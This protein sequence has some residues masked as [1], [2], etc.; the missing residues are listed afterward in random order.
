MKILHTGDWHIGKLLE[1]RSRLEEQQRVLDQFVSMAREQEAD[2]V[3]IAGDVFDNSHPSAAAEALFIP[4][5]KRFKP[6]RKQAG[7]DDCRKS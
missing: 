7:G 3:L 6:E 5:T 2:I 1:G 4:D